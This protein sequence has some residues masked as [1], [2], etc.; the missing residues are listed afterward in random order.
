MHKP[1]LWEEGGGAEGP[2]GSAASPAFDPEPH[3]CFPMTFSDPTF[4]PL[5][6]FVNGLLW[7]LRG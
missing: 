2:E 5:P 6:K 1:Q 3:Q 4:L 7:W